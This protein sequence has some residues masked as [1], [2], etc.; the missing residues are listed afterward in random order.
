MFVSASVKGEMLFYDF[1]LLFPFLLFF[2]LLPLLLFSPSISSPS[3]SPFFSSSFFSLSLFL[4]LLFLKRGLHRQTRLALD[5]PCLC[6]YHAGLTSC[7]TSFI[8]YSSFLFVFKLAYEA[9][10][11]ITMFSYIFSSLEVGL[12]FLP[13]LYSSYILASEVTKH[14]PRHGDNSGHLTLGKGT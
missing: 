6:F 11:V 1:L 8:L 14:G 9:M 3:A 10:S 4:C 13:I 7:G 2:S 5:F 12:V